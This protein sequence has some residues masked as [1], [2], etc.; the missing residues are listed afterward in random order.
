MKDHHGR[1]WCIPCGETDRRHK[2]HA[3]GGICEG[4]GESFSAS[5]LME[6]AG[7]FLCGPCRKRT[8]ANGHNQSDTGGILHSIKSIFRK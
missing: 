7:R 2:A 1:Y 6:I 8:F 3:Q 5:Q 4:C